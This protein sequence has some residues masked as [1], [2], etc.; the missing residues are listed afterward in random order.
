MPERDTITI[1]DS[2]TCSYVLIDRVR[3]LTIE[4]TV[5]PLDSLW[6]THSLSKTIV[7][8]TKTAKQ[9][10]NTQNY[11]LSGSIM[12]SIIVIIL[13]YREILNTIPTVL[14]NTFNYRAQKAIEEK[15]SSV[16]QRNITALISA[17]FLTFFTTLT[18][19]NYFKD[20]TGAPIYLLIPLSFGFM[21]G[22]WILKTLLLRFSGW[23]L[24]V[25]YPFWLIGKI[26]YN[27]LILSSIITIPVIIVPIFIAGFDEI[28]LVKI[29]IVCYLA[30]FVL[31]LIRVYQIIISYHFS[32]FFYILYLCTVE[33]LPI[34]LFT[35]FLLSY[36]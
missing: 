13:F 34:A 27:H 18:F 29:L 22:Y 30:L 7:P 10:D 6:G 33:I 20:T 3:E 21:I 9:S 4:Q 36:Q 35:N 5:K 24:R 23:V 19:G 1:T 17:L 15:L 11:I 8:N 28:L 25:H 31:Y 12:L 14:K 2:L 16:N 32:H 26:G